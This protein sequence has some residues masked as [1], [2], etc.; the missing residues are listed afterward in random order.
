MYVQLAR[1]DALE[2]VAMPYHRSP[3]HHATRITSAG[4][5]LVDVREPGE[6]AAGSLPHA[7]NIP[8]SELASRYRE[9]DPD[10]PVAV[11]CRSGGRSARAAGFLTEHG[12]TDVTN[13]EG[14][15]LAA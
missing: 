1:I 3:A 12:F 15:I 4:A 14:G 13:L 2:P 7:V 9:L 10:R 11:L 6:F 5:Q 8:L